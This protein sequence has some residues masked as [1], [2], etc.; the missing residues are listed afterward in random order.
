MK[1][2]SFLRLLGGAAAVSV[3]PTIIKAQTLGR[4]GKAPSGKLNVG[5]IG[6]G[7]ISHGHMQYVLGEPDLQLRWVCD[8]NKHV[9]ANTVAMAE[10]RYADS[11]GEPTF[12]GIKHTGEFR[13][14]MA[15]PD[16]DI[17]FNC[18][19]DHWHALVLTAAADAGKDIY[20]EK[21][22]SRTPAEGV[23]MVEAVRR[24]GIVCQIGSQQRSS[25]EFQRAIALARNG[26]LGRIKRVVVGLPPGGGIPD[27]VSPEPQPI[28]PE[29]DYDRW[30]GPSP[31]LPYLKERLDWNWRWR[32]EFAGGQL[33]DWINHHYDIAQLALG[34]NEE[35]PVAIKNIS[36]EFHHHPIYNT[37]I[38]YSLEAH[39]AGGQLIEV[40]S[41]NP[42]GVRIEGEDGWV[43]VDR[44]VIEHS[45]PAL[46]AMPLP[47]Q[48]FSMGGGAVAHRK[49]FFDCVATR[50]TPRSP[51]A[52]AHTTAMAAHLANAAMRAGLSEI[53]W[54]P[55]AQRVVNAPDAERFLVCNYRSPWHLPA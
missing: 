28:P 29:L 38:R 48:G 21:P 27:F 26:A 34:V 7:G 18:T 53:R 3:A 13:E 10:K 12:K 31:Y 52:Q 4:G 25:G 42:M 30:I 47:T 15:D 14:V 37:A 24:S 45:S 22:L 39:F 54:D 2:R 41:G 11:R 43:Y 46:R 23:A 40:S 35:V 44:G 51:I 16:V 33:T 20:S 50:G 8:V 36:A 1:R 49:N 5:F 17:I 9:A 6:A 55:A 32:Y 19:P